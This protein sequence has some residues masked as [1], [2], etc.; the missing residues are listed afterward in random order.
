M[1]KGL[2]IHS[3]AK[4]SIV[5]EVAAD[6]KMSYVRAE[7]LKKFGNDR[8]PG[9]SDDVVIKVGKIQLSRR[10]E[11]SMLAWSVIQSK[12]IVE[13]CT[14]SNS[15]VPEVNEAQRP[16]K[17]Q[18]N[19]D[20]VEKKENG[21]N[22]SH[23]EDLDLKHEKVLFQ[24]REHLQGLKELLQHNTDF[25]A[26]ARRQEWVKEIDTLSKKSAPET[27]IGCLGGTGVGKSSLLNA[28]CDEAAILPTSGSRG[29]TATVVE[30]RFNK[31][32]LN[33]S[34]KT[35]VYK[36]QVEFMSLQEWYDELKVLVDLCCVP[37]T[38]K[39]LTAPPDDRQNPEIAAAWSKLKA[40]YGRKTMSS[41]LGRPRADVWEQLSQDNHVVKL[42]SGENGHANTIV[43]EEGCADAAQAKLLLGRLSSLDSKLRKSKK[44]W[45]KKFR[46]KINEFV[47]RSGK[48]GDPQSWP[49][50][51]KVVLHG[52]WAVLSTGARLV[53]L[54]GVRDAN[55]AR[56]AVA[57][58]YLQHCHK[59]W[60]V[61][62]I[63]RAVVWPYYV[64]LLLV[65]CT[66]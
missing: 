22:K 21:D 28:L 29:C 34:D 46:S 3:C 47:Y 60:I 27:I 36:G 33:P 17:K 14:P 56:A 16:L 49:L 5:I 62:P 25:C 4:H 61:A 65:F 53:D 59:I 10:E 12:R 50:T 11:E 26:D 55:A 32:L 51:R 41:C 66:L 63:K 24:S 19:D 38:Q 64:C 1:K 8:L 54:P 42:L 2:L 37:A 6:D 31:D 44:T 13:L 43:V 39:I 18:R 15:G 58:S 35:T 45:A 9:K 52:P 57:S 20:Q 23:T 7:A 30:L 40:V 48:A